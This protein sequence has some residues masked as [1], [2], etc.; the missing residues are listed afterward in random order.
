MRGKITKRVI[1]TLVPGSRD[2]FLWD[3]D[4]AGFG[5]KCTPTG[6]KVYIV[7]YRMGGRGF[8]TRRYKIG[9]HGPFTPEEARERARKVLQGV[10]DGLDP[11]QAKRAQKHNTIEKLI[12]GF[13]ESRRT[14]GRR[15]AEEIKRVLD[16][17]IGKA[18]RARSV[19]S[20]T[21]ADIHHVLDAIVARGSPVIAN[22]TLAHIKTMFNWAKSR[23]IVAQS[24]ADNIEKPGDESSRERT[25]D[26]AELAEI[27]Q[28]AAKLDWP[29]EPA[30]KLLILTG[31]RREEVAQMRWSEL[32]LAERVWALPASR[33]K[34]RQPHDI[35]L[36]SLALKIIRAVT[37]IEDC[38]LVFSTN[39]ETAIS[40]WS[41]AK[42]RL[43]EEIGAAR[44]AKARDLGRDASKV[45]QMPDWRIHDLRRSIATGLANLGV[46]P[47][48]ADRILNHVPRKQK[49]QVMFVYN[50]A[51]YAGERREALELWGKHLERITQEFGEPEAYASDPSTVP[52]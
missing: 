48:V 38:D 42:R 4:L 41:R 30:I 9:A 27:W 25:P 5:L 40:G 47:I 11:M 13:I 28:A 21:K 18:W 14:K 46:A 45:G 3:R 51:A 34:N 49:G 44:R 15:S 39:G 43:D 12:E 19:A 29:F 17:E 7:Q 22:R 32:K 2:L 6:K 50:R 10:R 35:H 1:D 23:G 52:K 36:S 20:I 26:N 24:P 33:T 16:R 37:P 31:Q 8:P